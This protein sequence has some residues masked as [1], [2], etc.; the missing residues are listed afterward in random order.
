MNAGADRTIRARGEQGSA[1]DVA[2]ASKNGDLL[3][4]LE[5]RE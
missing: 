1:I 4:L 5:L 3:T 2:R